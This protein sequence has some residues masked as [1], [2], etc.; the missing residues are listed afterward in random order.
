MS[1]SAFDVAIVGGGIVGAACA[2]ECAAA[3]MKVVVLESDA[4]GS[5]ATAAGMGH[6][7][8]M[9]DSDAQF[10]LTRYSQ[11]LWRAMVAELP[12]DVEF[13]AA[14]TLWVAADEEEMAEVRRKHAYYGARDVP[15]EIL[16][17]Q[18]LRSA[19]PNLRADLAGALRVPE[20]AVVYPPCAARYFLERAR[21]RGAE[22]RVGARATEISGKGVR[23]SD[24]SFVSAGLTVNAAGAWSPELTPGLEVRKRKGHLVITDRYPSF[25]RHQIVELGYLKSAHSLTADSVAFNVQPRK[26]GQ[27]L[28][29]S[30][31]QFGAEH[32]DVDAH[33]VVRMLQR[34]CEYMPGLAA[35][36]SIRVWTGFR[37]ATPDK[38]PLI[39][40]SATDPQLWLATGHEGLGITTSLATA[41]LLV[42][43]IQGRRPAIPVDPYLPTR[44]PAHAH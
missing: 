9:D 42:D 38:L 2:M 7:V 32:K 11:E 6:I 18:A 26:T 36:S 44:E 1:E 4:V 37:A 21:Q 33:M 23:L 34:A 10:A 29:G 40:P 30:S 25:V 16:D 12:P 20:D 43:Q 5:G 41:K 3:G 27:L 31:R 24:G 35:L 22:A 13:V 28:I 19:E 8:V 17:A 14:G 39:G 15:T